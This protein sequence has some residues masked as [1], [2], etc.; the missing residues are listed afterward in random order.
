M[1]FINT[2]PNS[3][4]EIGTYFRQDEKKKLFKIVDKEYCGT[5]VKNSRSKVKNNER[6]INDWL[7][8]IEYLEAKHPNVYGR[9]YE[10]RLSEECTIVP[11]QELP[12]ALYE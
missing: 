6:Q 3:Q 5:L 12:R 11:Q 7:Y 8:T 2:R 10:G 1:P 9:Y 4:Y